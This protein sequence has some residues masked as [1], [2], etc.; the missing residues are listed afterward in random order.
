MQQKLQT[1]LFFTF[2]ICVQISII[3]SLKIKT[4]L[5]N[6]ST[7]VANNT[8]QPATN[9]TA[10]PALTNPEKRQPS[11]NHGFRNL[12]QIKGRAHLKSN[13][14]TA[15]EHRN[16][17]I[18]HH[19]TP[20]NLTDINNKVRAKFAKWHEDLDEIDDLKKE[21]FERKLIL[22]LPKKPTYVTGIA[23][24]NIALGHVSRHSHDF[25]IT[26][27]DQFVDAYHKAKN[28]KAK[29]VKIENQ[30]YHIRR[31]GRNFWYG[32]IKNGGGIA[33]YQRKQYILVMTH[34]EKMHLNEFAV[35]FQKIKHE[36]ENNKQ[37][38]AVKYDVDHVKQAKKGVKER[39]RK[40]RQHYWNA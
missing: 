35:F 10:T 33:V 2:L 8:A 17:F 14:Q 36:F 38:L 7:L 20:K 26:N 39:L 1:I 25:N 22:K 23:V 24:I 13:N 11:N 27:L 5:K 37:T 28:E 6:K 15:L 21:N 4:K 40:D 34:N 32:A 12:N 31:V 30:E 19:N 29:K 16:Q 9:T 3:D 18:V